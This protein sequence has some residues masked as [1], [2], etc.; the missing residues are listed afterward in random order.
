M[1]ERIDR[2]LQDLG[3]VVRNGHFVY[4]GDRHGSDYIDK[5]IFLAHPYATADFA[6]MLAKQF[7]GV[8]VDTVIGPVTGGAVLASWV[9][10]H[11]CYASTGLVNCVFA[12]KESGGFV[13]KRSFGRFVR[14]KRV[15]V[16]DDV[17]HT[18]D[19]VRKVVAAVRRAGGT[20]VGV[21]A[22]SNRG[23]ESAQ[24]LDV[25]RLEFLTA[26][27]FDTYAA[28]DCPLCRNG[29]PI[30]TELGHGARFLGRG[31]RL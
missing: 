9:A 19:T 17:L 2:R 18:G 3:A 14:N 11:L 6:G 4:S 26:H 22:I 13:V 30:N 1:N 21:G 25:P 10:T 15:L 27:T 5:S 29:V 31:E 8:E 23:D 16:V 12:D 7:A 28:S 20:V 24:S